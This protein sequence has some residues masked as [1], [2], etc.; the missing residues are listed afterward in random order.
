MEQERKERKRELLTASRMG[1]L[2]SCPRKHYWRY[3]VGL[4]STTSDAAALRFGTAWHAAMEARWRGAGF[5]EALAAALNT[6]TGSTLDEMQASMLAGLLDGY[7]ARYPAG[8]E[9]GSVQP[10]AQFAF[11]LEGSR[12]FDVAGKIDGIALLKDGR[13][14]LVEHKTTSDSLDSASDYWTRLRFNGQVLQYVDAAR[15]SGWSIETVIYDVVRKPAIRPKKNESIEDYSKRLADDCRERPDFYFARR[16][17]AILDQDLAEFAAQ[18]RAIGMSIL[19][20]R[21]TQKRVARPE[22]AWPRC[23]STMDCRLCEYASFCLQNFTVNMDAPPM[24]FAE[25]SP[26]EELGTI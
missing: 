20:Y 12:T 3:E 11:S 7:F 5:E 21:A 24:G 10:E 2:L 18:R 22:Q 9:I 13:H 4:R 14:A 26:N 23:V 15:R 6:A 1:A 19:N 17:V 16:E 8:D 25:M